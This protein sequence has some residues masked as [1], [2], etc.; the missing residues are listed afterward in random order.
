MKIVSGTPPN[1]GKIV[2]AFPDANIEGT[3]FTYGD[4]VYVKGGGDIPSSIKAH[5]AIH[6]QQQLKMGVEVWWDRYLVDSRFRLD[7]E[8]PAHRAEY[9]CYCNLKR[10]R[11]MRSRALTTIAQRL[12][13]PLYGQVISYT[14]A[15]RRIAA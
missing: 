11:N 4:T 13:S 7:Q 1:F 8:L 10:D 12:S 2:A 9:A 6:I 5:E 14:E 3:I 15:R